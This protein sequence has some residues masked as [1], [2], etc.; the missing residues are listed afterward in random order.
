M[1]TLR[2]HICPICDKP[3][4]YARKIGDEFVF[5]ESRDEDWDIHPIAYSDVRDQANIKCTLCGSLKFGNRSWN[6]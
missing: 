3:N 2:E 4:T 1:T 5:E 6:Y